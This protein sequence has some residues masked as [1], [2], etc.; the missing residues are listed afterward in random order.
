M[1]IPIWIYIGFVT[2]LGSLFV[3][4]KKKRSFIVY[5]PYCSNEIGLEKLRNYLCPKCENLVV[6]YKSSGNLEFCDD[7]K[8]FEC[9]HCQASNPQNVKHCHKCKGPN[10]QQVKF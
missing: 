1:D 6:Y 3:M 2:F 4:K 10:V 7:V 8:M 5:C 9:E